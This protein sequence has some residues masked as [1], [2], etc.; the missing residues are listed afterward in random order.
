MSD[1]VIAVPVETADDVFALRHSG[2]IAAA[3]FGLDERV[4]VRLATALS[5]LGREGLALGARVSAV[6][7]RADD[8]GL[9]VTIDG[10]SPEDL[11]RAHLGLDAARKLVDDVEVERD[12]AGVTITVF[13]RPRGKKKPTLSQIRAA[14][15]RDVPPRP[16][17]ELRLQNRDLVATL[18]EVKAQSEQLAQLNAELEETNRGVM[19]MYGQLA[20]ELEETNR[21]VVAL[22]A[23]LDDKT[24]QLNEASEAKTRFLANVSHELR[25]PVSSI[26]ALTKLMLE[27]AN[28]IDEERLQQLRLVSRSAGELLVL[29]NDLL[30]LAKAESGRLEPTVSRV[31]L[32]EV[33]GELRGT[34]RPL[35]RP[36]VELHVEVD[37]VPPIETDRV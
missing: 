10:F 15:K 11:E 14:L 17:D 34:L 3:A 12:D 35:T 9:E 33:A 29:V 8:G 7:K 16:L 30:D 13:M 5:E 2:R 26:I 1:K 22:Y 32:A 28:K 18:T 23:E 27:P 37:A 19:A 24:V 6:F 21:G 25:S 4:Q 36:G 31:D 20:G